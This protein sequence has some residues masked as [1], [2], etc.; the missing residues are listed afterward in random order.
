MGQQQMLLTV[1]T[2]IVVG[3]AVRIGFRVT[4]EQNMSQNRDQLAVQ[5]Q[6]IFGQAEAYASRP[7]TQGGGGGSY[8]GFRLAK[9]LA[10]TDV[11]TISTSVSGSSNLT[12]TGTGKVKGNN[13]KTPVRVVM[14]VTARKIKKISFAN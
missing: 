14:T 2:I 3:I 9:R 4:N 1:L 11:G 7:K 8:R 13:N 6:I 5:M 10:K 12:I